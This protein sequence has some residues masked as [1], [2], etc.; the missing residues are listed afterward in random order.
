MGQTGLTG[1]PG[2]L[3]AKANPDIPTLASLAFLFIWLT[4][5]LL[6]FSQLSILVGTH[7]YLPLAPPIALAG[8]CGLAILLRHRTVPILHSS[9]VGQP[10]QA[11]DKTAVAPAR[12]GINWRSM[13][14]LAVMAVL[15][16]GSHLYGLITVYAAEGY[17]SE[18][19]RGENS[20]LEVVYTGY[21][22]ADTWLLSHSK[23]TGTVGVVGGSATSLWYIANP[24]HEGKLQFVVVQYG[25]RSFPFDYLVWPMHLVQRHYSIPKQWRSHIVHTITGGGTTYCFIMARD[26]ST[27]TR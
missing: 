3:T 20:T 27:L 18:L 9:P 26:P 13:A 7:Y 4:S 2:Q 16:L 12:A 15:L 5:F 8:A 19:F 21:R 17:T 25:S 24:H 11:A 22:E 6:V 23:I 10:S 14:V 1:Q